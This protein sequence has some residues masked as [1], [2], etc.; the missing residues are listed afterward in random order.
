MRDRKAPRAKGAQRKPLVT[1]AVLRGL[2]RMAE[3]TPA[4]EAA[5][6]GDVLRA[7]RYVDALRAYVD[8][9]AAERAEAA[10]LSNEWRKANAKR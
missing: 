5:I 8:A 6:N 10:R 9:H 1:G 3:L 4:S 2:A 7:L